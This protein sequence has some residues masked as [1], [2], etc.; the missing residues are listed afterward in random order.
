MSE[1]A[2]EVTTAVEPGSNLDRLINNIHERAQAEV[3]EILAAAQQQVGEIL[4]AAEPKGKS[5]ADQVQAEAERLAAEDRARILGTA[6]RDAV[7]A[8]LGAQAEVLA[9]TAAYVSDRLIQV[10][11]EAYERLLKTL[12]LAAVQTGDEVVRWSQVDHKERAAKIMATVN[13]ALKAQGR[14]GQ[15]VL[16]EALGSECK[17]G[18]ILVGEDYTVNATVNVLTELYFDQHEPEIAKMLFGE[19]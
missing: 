4:A 7:E 11:P 12:L 5:L 10:N 14:T 16:G 8:K 6:R 9:E 15:L 1:V 17:G 18:F 2:K 19:L 13:T 3:A